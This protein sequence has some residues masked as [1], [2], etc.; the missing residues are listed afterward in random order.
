MLGTHLLMQMT[1]ALKILSKSLKA[2]S[3]SLIALD[4]SVIEISMSHPNS[5]R[6]INA[7]HSVAWGS[8]CVCVCVMC[9]CVCVCVCV[10]VRQLNNYAHRIDNL[11]TALDLT[12][13]FRFQDLNTISIVK[14]VCLLTTAS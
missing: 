3:R 2:P 12:L 5:A 6:L 4:I 11:K 10:S 7:T 1:M 9:V 8:Q 13:G 14:M